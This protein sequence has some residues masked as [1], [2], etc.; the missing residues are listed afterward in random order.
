MKILVTGGSGLIGKGVLPKL[1]ERGHDVRELSR[2]AK[3]G[4]RGDVADAESI[5]GAAAGCDAILHIAGIA[6]EEPPERTFARVNVEGTRN[7]LG[8]AERSGVKR[9]VYISSL[10]A[11]RGS[12]AY[13]KSKLEAETLVERSPLDW[14]IVRPGNVFGPGD[15]VISLLL[16]LVRTLPAVPVVDLGDQPFQ[17]VWYD[18]LGAAIAAVL[19]RDDLTHR[20]LEFGGRETTSMSDLV[21]RFHEITGRTPLRVPVPS[22]LAAL[23]MD[24]NKLTMLLEEN[25][26]HGENGFDTLDIEPTP[27]D[28]ALRKLGEAQPENVDEG[29]GKLEHKRY[30]AHIDGSRMTATELMAWFRDHV[31][32]TMPVEAAHGPLNVGE[33]M[34]ISLP[35][36]GDVQVRAEVVEP[37]RLILA[38]I[39]GHPLAGIV[40]FSTRGNV[41]FTIDIYARSA[42]VFDYVAMHTV[43]AAAQQANW[44]EVMRR[45]IDAS[46][47]TSEGIESSSEKL[48]EDDEKAADA[49]MARIVAS[50]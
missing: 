42:N 33:T 22:P 7:L 10:G 49:R 4:W 23:G 30:T 24:V 8:E 1:Q 35:L 50:T 14:T 44:L 12:S 6:E 36:R 45:V 13:H 25:V 3:D 37:N 11:D 2:H 46:G 28:D 29:V 18:D 19:E 32:E 31:G 40:E 5:R 47:G 20:V 27:L 15:E 34:T 41:D 48:N 9:F 26:I 21:K 43:G 39:A 17:P 16:R 38:T